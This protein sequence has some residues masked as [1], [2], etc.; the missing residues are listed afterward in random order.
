VG[1]KNRYASLILLG[2]LI[3]PFLTGTANSQQLPTAFISGRV[4]DQETEKPLDNVIVYLTN[5][6]WGTSTD[7]LGK[8]E[9]SNI[10]SG[11]Y[12]LI[13]SRVG[14]A[15]Q[16]RHI[17]LKE[18][19]TL[20][21][22]IRLVA[23]PIQA[24]EVEVLG[25]RPE[26]VESKLN[27]FPSTKD[28]SYCV[29]GVETSLPIGILF[30]DSA[31]YMY[32]LEPTIVDE[33]KFIRLWL[34]YSNISQR[35]HDFNPY[36]AIKI[37]FITKESY[38]QNISALCPS[39]IEMSIS[40]QSAI[41]SAKEI[42]CKQIEKM[43]SLHRIALKWELRFLASL[44]STEAFAHYVATDGRTQLSGIT[45]EN[46]IK[47]SVNDGILKRHIVYPNN[48][49]HGFLFFPY[50]GLN[51]KVSENKFYEAY[52]NQYEL[53]IKTPTETRTIVFTAH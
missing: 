45:F 22:E 21:Y 37:N 20:F 7:T 2:A 36:E 16:L 3:Y 52:L 53:E 24:S 38:Y 12:D 33:E 51:W 30:T 9:I 40:N 8:F 28:K 14:Y 4:L 44:M 6:F 41:D 29:Y 50:P 10:D 15:R 34:L 25:E 23:Q 35:P 17:H 46:I 43:A 31:F 5:T 39:E 42:F 13:I 19:D 49:V 18:N 47:Q 48:S 1:N 26:R 11:D 27:L 32:A